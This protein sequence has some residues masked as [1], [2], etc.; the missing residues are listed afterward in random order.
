[1]DGLRYLL[2]TNIFSALIRQ[3]QGPVAS[4]RARRGYATACTSISHTSPLPK[5]AGLITTR[6]VLY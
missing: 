1:M 4:T 6:C 3:P 5:A 2:D